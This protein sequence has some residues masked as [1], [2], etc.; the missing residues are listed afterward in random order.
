MELLTV[1]NVRICME[2]LILPRD[3]FIPYYEQVLND[4]SVEI[5][6]GAKEMSP[7]FNFLIK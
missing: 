3:E 6:L 5:K 1:P 4:K 7:F 2:S